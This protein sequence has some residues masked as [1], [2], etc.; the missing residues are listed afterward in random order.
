MRDKVFSIFLSLSLLCVTLSNP[1]LASKV[2][3][4]AACKKAGA[5]KVFNKKTYTCIK[6]GK[7]LYWD[8]GKRSTNPR[9]VPSVQPS[10]S[11]SASQSPSP[12]AKQLRFF[13]AHRTENA[14]ELL[15]IVIDTNGRLV[16]KNR[17]TS[18]PKMGLTLLDSRGGQLL[19]E[20]GSSGTELYLINQ[21]RTSVALGIK[22]WSGNPNL[23]EVK[24]G[25]DGKSLF[26]FDF[27]RNFYRYDLSGVQAVRST[28]FTSAQFKSAVSLNKGDPDFDWVENF[29]IK[30]NSEFFVITKH[31]KSNLI[32][33]WSMTLAPG[34]PA[35]LTLTLRGRA[36]AAGDFG[37]VDM[38]LSP[39][40]SKIA[41]MYAASLL[42][43]KE[44]LVMVSTSDFSF[45]EVSSSK[46][47]E[48][49]N[50]FLAWADNQNLLM[51][52]GLVW[53]ADKDGG[54]ITCLLR[55]DDNSMCRNI[56][57]VSGYSLLGNR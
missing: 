49:D 37:S 11:A 38:S 20:I 33:L 24:I 3:P 39:D 35:G 23:D 7:K 21:N 43:P 44:R 22:K 9:T 2:T 1:A 18:G 47:F 41:F 46:L 27:D 34:T 52:I 30:N 45:K 19:A 16:S 50:Y 57:T 53:T 56:E 6:L 10:G 14:E 8:N 4:G 29:E 36:Q 26:A 40:G 25:V 15:E 17:I 55:L 54:R 13:Q 42:T 28:L 32:Q 12:I 31:S 51:T 5:Q 48:G